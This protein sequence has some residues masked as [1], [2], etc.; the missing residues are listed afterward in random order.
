[1][2]AT[3]EG[4]IGALNLHII[5]LLLGGDG[6]VGAR[7]GLVKR[8]GFKARALASHVKACPEHEIRRTD[9]SG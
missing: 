7:L 3:A 1:M 4:L 6:I 9:D 8:P 2:T 5:P